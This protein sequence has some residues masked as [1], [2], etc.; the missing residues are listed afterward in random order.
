MQKASELSGLGSDLGEALAVAQSELNGGMKN[1]NW[2]L[3]PK[4]GCLPAA[5][6]DLLCEDL[7][8]E[9]RI[10]THDLALPDGIGGAIETLCIAIDSSQPERVRDAIKERLWST[11]PA[12]RSCSTLDDLLQG[13]HR[14]MSREIRLEEYGIFLPARTRKFAAIRTHSFEHQPAFYRYRVALARV[15]GLPGPMAEFLE[16]LFTNCPNH[17]FRETGC[18]ASGVSRRGQL[19]IE[20]P[21]ARLTDHDIIAWAARSRGFRDV[22]S[23][24]ENLQKYFLEHEPRT[25]ACEV[26]VWMESGEL[27]DYPDILGTSEPLTGHIDVLRGEADGRLGVWDYKPH[28]AAE[29]HAHIQVFL[30][31]LMLS[32]R[33]GLPL[34]AFLCG[35]F[36]EQDAYVFDPT[37]VK[38][39]PE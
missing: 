36:D 37:Q 19:G 38:H 22:S 7:R 21:V 27:A 28:A 39:V 34:S 29:R 33:T 2:F 8:R 25:V 5:W 26:P 20:M 1:L 17:L 4:N 13:R 30:Y 35:Y 9:F 12:A 11:R 23:R 10:A 15:A 24:H 31:A 16:A 6:C 3:L 14:K 32:L 18:R